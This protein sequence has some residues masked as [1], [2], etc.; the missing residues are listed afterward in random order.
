[1]LYNI[2]MSKK[3]TIEEIANLAGVSITT[4]SFVLNNR[5]DQ[6]ISEETKKKVWQI[7]NL[8][9]YRPSSFAKN[10]RKSSVKKIIAVYT[11][12]SDNPLKK[13]LI[14]DFLE[15]IVTYFSSTDY[16]IVFLNDQI[17]KIDI[18]DAVVSL[19]L[20]KS[21]FHNFGEHNFIPLI[22]VDSLIN[23]PVFFQITSDYEKLNSFAENHFS[24]PFTFVDILHNDIQLNE[25][26]KKVFQNVIFINEINDLLQ[27]NHQNI[28]VNNEVL[29][30]LLPANNKV[31]FNQQLLANKYSQIVKC[32]QFAL[33]HKNHTLH[34]YKI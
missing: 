10:I 6:K 13:A 9:G 26:I 7:V 16:G 8:L 15:N 23:D 12:F 28:V 5:D 29:R 19:D 20:T 24:S 30:D 11:S 33:T 1:M 17:E 2:V 22:A 34:N 25:E 4:V 21:N 31:Y 14:G 18:A 3:V 32:T 27:I